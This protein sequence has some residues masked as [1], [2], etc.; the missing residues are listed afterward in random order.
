MIRLMRKRFLIL[1]VVLFIAGCLRSNDRSTTA[2]E[3][4]DRPD[5]NVIKTVEPQVSQPTQSNSFTYAPAGVEVS[6]P[7]GWKQSKL[8]EREWAIVP[9]EDARPGQSISMDVPTLPPHIPGMIPIG[10]VRAGFIKDLGEKYG[11]VETQDLTPPAIADCSS[12]MVRCS[13]S[14]DGKVWQETALLMV[15]GDAVYI[16]R[17]NSDTDHEQPTR[18]AFDKVLKSIT[19]TK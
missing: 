7:A 3:Q 16:F 11:K 6:W 9:V 2:G 8:D 12:K 18:E 13:W 17:A 14:K 10:R 4:S 1:A 5:G 19:W 15:H